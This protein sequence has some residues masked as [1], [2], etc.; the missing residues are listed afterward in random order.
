MDATEICITFWHGPSCSKNLRLR[1]V[2]RHH[3]HVQV[4]ELE[5]WEESPE[6]F[7]HQ[8]DSA[9]YRENV[10]PCAELLF[11]TLLQVSCSCSIHCAQFL[12]TQDKTPCM[13]VQ[14]RAL[15]HSYW[16]VSGMSL[17]LGAPLRQQNIHVTSTGLAN[18]GKQALAIQLKPARWHWPST[19][20]F[21]VT[22]LA[23]ACLV[24]AR[25]VLHFQKKLS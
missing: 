20:T 7:H 12:Q 24:H 3:F 18:S 11:A 6:E 1:D 15:L 13:F 10:R 8:S 5:H 25:P 9:A 21:A 17:Q 14:L 22:L 23:H 4:R 2:P 16:C 19:L